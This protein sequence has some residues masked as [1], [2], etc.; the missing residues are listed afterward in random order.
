MSELLNTKILI[1][2]DEETVRESLFAVLTARGFGVATAET[3][4][5]ALEKIKKEFY[6]ILLVD[7]KL[8]DMDGL[9][10][11]KEA[12]FISKDSVPIVVTGY[13]SVETAVD[14][15]RIGA[16]DYLIKP[17]DID[18]LIENIKMILNERDDYRRGLQ[19]LQRVITAKLEPLKDA[20]TR[21]VCGK[22]KE[23]LGLSGNFFLKIL[24]FPVTILKGFKNFYFG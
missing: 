13:S 10:L 8:T 11:I 22:G 2:E 4:R 24:F 20:D 17:V 16:H 12:A 21:I 9:S 1:I 18:N 3:G 15:M 14:A 19:A 7:Y 6:D 23:I 5:E